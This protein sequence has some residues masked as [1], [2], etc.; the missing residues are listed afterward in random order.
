MNVFGIAAGVV[1]I[2]AAMAL[3]IW[4][5]E[6]DNAGVGATGFAVAALGVLLLTGVV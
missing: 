1:C 3:V 6:D 5:T 4:A 2:W